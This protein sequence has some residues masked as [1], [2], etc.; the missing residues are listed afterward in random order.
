MSTEST[1]HPRFS[2]TALAKFLDEVSADI[3][4]GKFSAWV[5]AAMREKRER[6][7][8]STLVSEMELAHGPADEAAVQR[9]M[10]LLQ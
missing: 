3:P 4:K 8:L 2:A 1:G 7:N 9:A 10:T 5:Y 6:D